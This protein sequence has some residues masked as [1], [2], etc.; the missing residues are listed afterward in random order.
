[1]NRTIAVLLLGVSLLT[2]C[3]EDMVTPDDPAAGGRLVAKTA[4]ED[5]NLPSIF[6]NGTH[7]HAQTFGDPT[8]PMIVFLHGGPG[9]DYRNALPAAQLADDGYFMVFYDQRGSGLSQRYDA[10]EYS[11]Q[12]MLDDLTAVIDHYRTAYTQPVFLFGHSW[13]AMLAAAY[14]NTYPDRIT[15]VVFAEAGGFNN[16]L[17]DEYGSMSRKLAV[18][19]EATN[20]IFYYDQLL[21]GRENEHEIL[22]YKLALQSP[23]SYAEGND[24]GVEG[25]SPFWRYGAVV[26]RAFV[27]IAEEEG[28]DFTTQLGRYIPPV[29]LL[30]GENNQAYGRAFADKE[31]AFLPNATIAEIADTGHEMIWF[32]WPAVYQAVLPYFNSFK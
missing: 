15:G 30:Y 21:T 26:L 5:P 31:A 23:Y 9:G 29:L 4:D 32:Q 11:I 25:P 22:D 14:V 2:S 19:S 10:A 24:E 28:F 20:D 12:I 18:L 13:G 27:N 17:L 3:K 7:L 1:M 6:V 8:D 16:Q